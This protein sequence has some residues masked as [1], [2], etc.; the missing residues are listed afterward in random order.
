MR[1][2]TVFNRVVF[3]YEKCKRLKDEFICKYNLFL[4]AQFCGL[5]I[6]DELWCVIFVMCSFKWTSEHCGKSQVKKRL[7]EVLSFHHFFQR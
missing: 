5:G 7:G 1:I 4:W 6:V 2:S 3:V